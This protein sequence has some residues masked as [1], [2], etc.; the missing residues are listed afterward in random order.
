MDAAAWGWV[1]FGV[2]LVP[3]L[4]VDLRLHLRGRRTYSQAL[5]QWDRALHRGLSLIVAAAM[6]F[7][8]WHFFG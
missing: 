3:W 8:W 6:V 4:L 2:F 5:Y 7:L 1:V